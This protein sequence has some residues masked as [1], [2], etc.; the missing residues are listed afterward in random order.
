MKKIVMLMISMMLIIP[1]GIVSLPAKTEAA[2]S[3]GITNI[4]KGSSNGVFVGPT[5]LA[6]E[7]LRLYV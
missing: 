4:G 7:G 6:A 3:F 5:W 2:S 1:A